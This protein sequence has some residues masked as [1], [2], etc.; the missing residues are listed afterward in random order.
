MTSFNQT[1]HILRKDVRHLYP[2]ITVSLSLVALFAW[3][4][5]AVWPGYLTKMAY[6]GA[7]VGAPPLMAVLLHLLVPLSWLILISRVVHDESLVGDKQFW[8]TRPYTWYSLLAAKLIFIG[9]LICLPMLA[10][11]MFLVHY[12]GLPVLSNLPGLL[13]NIGSLAVFFLLPFTVL[14]SVTSSFGPLILLILGGLLYLGLVGLLGTYLQGS[15]AVPPYA[16]VGWVVLTALILIGVLLYQYIERK[17]GLSQLLLIWTPIVTVALLLMAPAGIL[18]A[19]AYPEGT[20]VA[21]KVDLDPMQQQL[22]GGGPLLVGKNMVMTLPL[23]VTGVPDGGLVESNALR[24]E[25]T[26]AS[27]FH[28]LSPWQNSGDMMRNGPTRVDME[29]PA[30]VVERIGSETVK[31]RLSLALEHLAPEIP[32]AF[33][34][35]EADHTVPGAGV[36][37]LVG[38]PGFGQPVCRYALR[39]PLT[40]VETE[41]QNGMCPL[42]GSAPTTPGSPARAGIGMHHNVFS[43]DPVQAQGLRFE[44]GGDSPEHPHLHALCAGARVQMRASHE[45]GGEQ[46]HVE[47]TGIEITPYLKHRAVFSPGPPP[48]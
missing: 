9:G 13:A 40:F 8:V 24:V 11:Q 7:Q 35:D 28:W 31:V 29:I 19:H 6:P 25:L 3:I 46:I 23:E 21:A 34:I 33:Q 47:Q 17:T 5:P 39:S 26:S 15:H 1:L 41:V 30:S 10:A 20:T 43:F 45:A 4:A 37:S 38:E 32:V 42:D 44:V 36:C 27:G 14:A 22:S 16:L 18:F 48:Q 12:A 2:E